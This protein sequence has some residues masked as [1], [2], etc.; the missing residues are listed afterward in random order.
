MLALFFSAVIGTDAEGFGVCEPL[1][2]AGCFEIGYNEK[3]CSRIYRKLSLMYHPDK[4]GSQDEMVQI[5]SCKGNFGRNAFF[6]EPPPEVP[7]SDLMFTTHSLLFI[8]LFIGVQC[9]RWSKHYSKFRKH[10]W[11][12][13]C[14]VSLLKF[15]HTLI[16]V[17][18]Y[19]NMLIFSNIFT[20]VSYVIFSIFNIFFV[21][22]VLDML[23]HEG[24]IVVKEEPKVEDTSR[25]NV[26]NLKVGG[27]HRDQYRW[28]T[29][30]KRGCGT[31]GGKGSKCP[32]PMNRPGDKEKYS[33]VNEKNAA[34]DKAY[35]QFMREALG[36][37]GYKNFKDI[38]LESDSESESDSSEDTEEDGLLEKM[39]GMFLVHKE[40]NT[41]TLDR[42][43]GLSKDTFW[44]DCGGA[45]FCGMVCIDMAV[46]KR[47]MCFDDYLKHSG[48]ELEAWNVVGTPMYLKKYSAHQG[49]NLEIYRETP[50]G[51]ICVSSFLNSPGFKWVKL[52]YVEQ[53]NVIINANEPSVER[54]PLFEDE[55]ESLSD[56]DVGHYVLICYNEAEDEEIGVLGN[57]SFSA[58]KINNYDRRLAQICCV[59]CAGFVSLFWE[60]LMTSQKVSALF[61]VMLCFLVMAMIGWQRYIEVEA[62]YSRPNNDDRRSIYDRRD[63]IKYQDRY[64]KVLV[65]IKF[66]F[67][68]FSF[69][70]KDVFL[71]EW[72]PDV[73]RYYTVSLVKFTQAYNEM[74]HLAGSGRDPMLGVGLL[75]KLRE[76]N[77]DIN[78]MNIHYETYAL[79][80]R[81]SPLLL[82]TGHVEDLRGLVKCN[83]PN[84]NP[85]MGNVDNVMRNQFRGAGEGRNYVKS[86]ALREPKRGVK[87]AVAPIG[88]ITNRNG[89][90][91]PG[92]FP[93]TDS[94]GLFQAFV[95]RSM[96][97]DG[98]FDDAL[99]EEYVE[100][101]SRRVDFYLEG[102]DFSGLVEPDCVDSFVANNKG[103]KSA[104]Y[105]KSVVND[106]EDYRS[107]KM[108][109]R[110][111]KN[112]NK[113]KP[114]VKF[115]DAAKKTEKGIQSKVRLI[116]AMSMRMLVEQ[117][118][119]QE[120]ISAWNHGRFSERQVKGLETDEVLKRISEVT[121]RKHN[122]TDYSSFEASI[123]S[124]IKAV[125]NYA[126]RRM[127]EMAGYVNTLKNFNENCE[128]IHLS[129]QDGVF[130]L[131]SRGSGHGYT[132]FANGLDNGM[133]IEF[134]ASKLGFDLDDIRYIVE[135]DD[136]IVDTEAY[137]VDLAK[138]L[139]LSMS[140]DMTGTVEGDNDFLCS[141]WIEG[142]RYLNV[143]KMLSCLWVKGTQNLSKSKQMYLLRCAGLSLHYLSPGHPILSAVVRRIGI[144]TKGC[145]KFKN[146]EKYLDNSWKQFDYGKSY[147]RTILTD[148]SMRMNI[149]TGANGFP[150]ISIQDQMMI[151]NQFDDLSIY[152]FYVGEVFSDYPQFNDRLFDNKRRT[153][154]SV[155]TMHSIVEMMGKVNN[156]KS[157]Y[158]AVG[159]GKVYIVE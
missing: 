151:E 155:E 74:Q 14:F 113:H 108:C 115:E 117:S 147:P 80:R 134:C 46:F 69:D 126:I 21:D 111:L 43:P 54:A 18:D 62:V 133:I 63:K 55:D 20:V 19:F 9:N 71:H 53:N 2:E 57:I 127:C 75:S 93:V 138:K 144:E 98:K 3:E 153:P 50:D 110:R 16:G 88:A 11:F 35:R 103:K 159:L 23:I 141:R 39:K 143:P 146:F 25:V 140:Q 61:L 83:T 137:S 114:F 109:G 100:F 26:R 7:L 52:L 106:Y 31:R 81:I 51:L 154:K 84:D 158:G 135:G 40:P 27:G 118:P 86:Y 90:C 87:V 123:V 65:S 152:N 60:T 56:E 97:T 15:G 148:D 47:A 6:E 132:S 44:Y 49:V 76:V 32:K 112:F 70:A 92:F 120:L 10:M 145:Q 139:G 34:D 41:R 102:T 37:H 128:Y 1:A 124:G 91:G 42:K 13:W 105:I 116:M 136:G 48:G 125:E 119:L 8:G 22:R 99:M 29:A 64:A 142:K 89:V 130:G 150:P 30:A 129:C 58:C 68:Y 156:L 149:A 96:Q 95:G 28:N 73:S 12:R 101:A 45:P 36:K 85:V 5:N 72:F 94:P 59:Y 66:D 157:E 38:G 67:H 4:M 104:K 131:G 122:V 78:L 82:I 79:L 121:D 17:V 107:G 33:K 77:T 24:G